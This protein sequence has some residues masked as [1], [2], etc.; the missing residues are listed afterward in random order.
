M[1]VK[2]SVLPFLG[3]V[4]LGGGNSQGW[5]VKSEGQV[6]RLG[7]EGAGRWEIHSEVSRFRYSGC[8]HCR[9]QLRFI[10]CEAG[11][12]GQGHG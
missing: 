1:Q 2:Q 7:R 8:V 6:E 5:M 9:E 11:L 3:L 4:T 12:C 10:L